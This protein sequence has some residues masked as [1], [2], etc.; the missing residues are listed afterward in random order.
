MLISL[1]LSLQ[2]DSR[3]HE[4]LCAALKIEKHGQSNLVFLLET[5]H[6]PLQGEEFTQYSSDPF[7]F[8]AKLTS[9]DALSQLSSAESSRTQPESLRVQSPVSESEKTKYFLGDRL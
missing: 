8:S 6:S 7:N 3:K 4:R 2:N 5:A 1:S 9:N